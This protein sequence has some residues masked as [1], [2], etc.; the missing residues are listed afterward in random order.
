MEE[1][2]DTIIVSKC[3][4]FRIKPTME[5]KIL[6][7]TAMRRLTKASFSILHLLI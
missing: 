3:M 5:Q 1:K 7:W 2:V 6:I 4:E